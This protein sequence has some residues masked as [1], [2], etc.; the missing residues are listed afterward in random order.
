MEILYGHHRTFGN[1]CR[2]S[3][4][5][6]SAVADSKMTD[7]S[8]LPLGVDVSHYQETISWTTLAAAG[9]G[10]GIIKATQSLATDPMFITNADGAADAGL[11]TFAYPFLTPDDTAETVAN[12]LSVTGGMVPALDWEEAGVSHSII[13]MWIKGYEDKSGRAGLAYYGIDPPDELTAL[14]GSWPRWLPEYAAQ[15][16]L[17]AWD[18]VSTPD[19]SREWL[20]WQYTGNGREPGVT[21]TI[22]LNRCAVPL[23]TLRAWHDTGIFPAPASP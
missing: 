13:E 20:L 15:P 10:Y 11:I 23:A 12:F 9:I 18:G 19:W 17:P 6:W 7:Y 22:D 16:R 5:T 8:T 21:T 3:F 14:I 2:I 4:G 1:N